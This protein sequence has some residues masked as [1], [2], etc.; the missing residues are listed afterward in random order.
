[1]YIYIHIYIYIYIPFFTMNHFSAP[2]CRQADHLETLKYDKVLVATGGSPRKLF[3]P[4]SVA[5]QWFSVG[6]SLGKCPANHG[7]MAS[8]SGFSHEKW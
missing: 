4:G 5:R 2:F 7:K 1:M 3:V 6:K 8:Y